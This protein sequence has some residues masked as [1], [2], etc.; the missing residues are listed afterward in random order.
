ML[1]PADVDSN[2]SD[3]VHLDLAE[4]VA[5]Q[6]WPATPMLPPDEWVL[7]GMLRCLACRRWLVA[8]RW[9]DQAGTRAYS[10][11]PDCVQRDL[12]ASEVE[13]HLL[14]GA[15]IRGAV[16]ATRYSGARPPVTAEELDRWR[17]TDVFDRRAVM[18]TAFVRVDVTARGELRPVWRHAQQRLST[19]AG[20][21]RCR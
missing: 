4:P 15:L 17:A 13:D 3:R 16:V 18:L 8:V 1:T 7:R 20:P 12:V 11:G 21:A 6:P 10:C 14:L 2:P 5:E 19:L 9:V